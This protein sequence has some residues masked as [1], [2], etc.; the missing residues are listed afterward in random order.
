[1]TSKQRFVAA[2][3]GELPDRVPVAPDISNYIPCKRTGLP[4]WEIY[5]HEVMPLWKAYMEAMAYYGGDWWNTSCMPN[6]VVFEPARVEETTREEYRKDMDAMVRYRTIKTPDG[7]LTAQSV[8]MRADP[9]T[10]HE[11]PIKDLAAD[12]KKV[13]WLL[14]A[15]PT[16]LDMKLWNEMK[17]ECEKYGAAFGAS[18]GYPGFHMWCNMCQGGVE[19]LTYAAIDNPE[20]LDEWWQL[21]MARGT[22][23][24]ELLLAAKPDYVL[25]GGSGTLT[26]SSP[27]LV[28]KYTIPALAKWTRMCRE[29]GVPTLLHSCGKSRLLV[30]ILAEDTAL[31]MVNPLEIPPMGDVDLAEVKR[32][33]G[34][35]LGLMG[36]LHTTQVMLKGSPQLVRQRSL[37]A[38]RDAGSG[39]RFILS[40]GDQCPRETPDENLFAMIQAAKE[41]GVYD[42]ST[43]EL[44]RLKEAL[45]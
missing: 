25:L 41:Y 5:F 13:R 3:K 32:A 18:V 9:P 10:P 43:G 17:A 15:M 19:T 37:E 27:D 38:M 8:C 29:A 21:D 45:A 42:R 31:D 24:M 33:R 16:G 20:I 11:K 22:R 35:R 2:I 12:W 23:T 40:S 28:R 26:M 14:Q 34:K 39:G 30:D 36:N 4:Y 7:V 6:A 1:M 44:P